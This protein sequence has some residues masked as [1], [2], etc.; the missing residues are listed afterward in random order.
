MA[1]LGITISGLILGIIAIIFG[2][3]VLA[4]PRFLRYLVGIYFILVGIL[5]V[6]TAI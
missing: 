4:F 1:L 2:V 3:L 5:A 6:I